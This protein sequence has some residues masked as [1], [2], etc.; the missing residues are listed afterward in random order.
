MRKSKIVSFFYQV[1]VYKTIPYTK[2]EVRECVNIISA[3][4]T[5]AVCS[6]ET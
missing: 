1:S 6:S 5:E 4:K 2:E 3:I